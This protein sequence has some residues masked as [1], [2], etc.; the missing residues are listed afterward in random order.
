LTAW[1]IAVSD[2]GLPS[3]VD[4]LVNKGISPATLWG[5]LRP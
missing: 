5:I 1:E 4:A 2:D 3:V